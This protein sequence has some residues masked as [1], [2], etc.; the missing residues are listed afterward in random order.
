MTKKS[1]SD[2]SGWLFNAAML[3]VLLSAVGAL[4]FDIYLASTQWILV[5]ILGIS[6]ANYLKK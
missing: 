3:A 6:L 2:W 4:G 5:A 1:S